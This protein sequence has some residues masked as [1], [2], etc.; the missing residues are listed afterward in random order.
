MMKTKSILNRKI[1]IESINANA[2]VNDWWNEINESD[3]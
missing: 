1:K 2:N 3:E